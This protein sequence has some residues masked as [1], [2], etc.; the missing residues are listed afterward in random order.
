MPV[1]R[2]GCLS[3][4]VASI[5]LVAAM[6]R[7]AGRRD[8]RARDRR[9]KR[10]V[11]AQA[12]R[13]RGHPPRRRARTDSVEFVRRLRQSLDCRN[14][15]TSIV[16]MASLPHAARVTA[17]RDAGVTEFLRKPFAAAHLEARLEAI[18][19]APRAAVETDGY[20]G[21]DR[22]RRAGTD[23]GTAERRER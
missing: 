13:F 22:R 5:D 18:R 14:R 10:D 9:A 23:F 6:L 8:I 21:P 17:A 12:P 2:T 4:T 3:P 20:V 7:H 19:R 15:L 16:M 11:R 1:E